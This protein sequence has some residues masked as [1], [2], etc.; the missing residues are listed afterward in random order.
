MQGDG[1]DSLSAACKGLVAY[2]EG[3]Y[4]MTPKDVRKRHSSGLNK[5]NGMFLGNAALSNA[6]GGYVEEFNG[7][8]Y[9]VKDND[10]NKTVAII[11]GLDNAKHYDKIYHAKKEFFGLR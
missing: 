4:H 11:R 3:M 6:S 8:D 5:V 10:T 9:M 1:Y 2:H 7:G